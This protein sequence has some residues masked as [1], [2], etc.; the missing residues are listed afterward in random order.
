MSENNPFNQYNIPMEGTPEPQGLLDQFNLPPAF[1]AFLRKNSKTIWIV[2]GC[3]SVVVVVASL[4]DSYR[5]HTL[6]KAGAALDEALT[7][8]EKQ[9]SLL[10]NVA[11]EYSS[12]PSA[13]WAK[14]ELANL[15]VEQKEL[16]KAVTI[17]VALESESGLDELIKP[18]VSFKLAGLY[19]QQEHMEK[20]L[21]IYTVQYLEQ[22]NLAGRENQGDPAK[23]IIEARVKQ[24]MH[25]Q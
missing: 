4:Y 15:Y 17:L 22:L 5:T 3:V 21:G 12:T 13:T 24:L 9:E 2:I 18:L 7:A 19:E 8:S 14:V 20:A 6:N 10:E 23:R 11:A 25:K 16:D 1:V